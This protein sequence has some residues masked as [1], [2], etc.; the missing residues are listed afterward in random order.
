MFGRKARQERDAARAEL[1]RSEAARVDLVERYNYLYHNHCSLIRSGERLRQEH[2][3]LKERCT[4]MQA[5]KFTDAELKKLIRLC[6][7][8]KHGDS[9]SA[10]EMTQRLLEMRN[11]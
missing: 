8:D 2:E 4:R 9:Q 6:H 1:A 11:K 10:T 5:T 3:A 7:P